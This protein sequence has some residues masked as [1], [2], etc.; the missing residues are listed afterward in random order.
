MIECFR[1]SDHLSTGKEN[2]INTNELSRLY[3]F[4]SREIR[5]LV[6]TERKQ[7]SMICSDHNGYYLAESFAEV[8]TWNN[9]MKRRIKN[10]EKS[11][12]AVM[13]TAH[14]VFHE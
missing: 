2:A 14:D 5:S 11:C 13:Q 4:N 6:E 3:G 7:G 9:S 1:I 8:L 12:A 10:M